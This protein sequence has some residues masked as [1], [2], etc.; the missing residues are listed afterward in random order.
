M[1][2]RQ[3]V[4]IAFAIIGLMFVMLLLETHR[5]CTEQGYKDCPRIGSHIWPDRKAR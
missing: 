2:N 4:A 3:F 5:R 1:T